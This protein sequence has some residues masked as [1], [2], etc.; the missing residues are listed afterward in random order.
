MASRVHLAHGSSLSVVHQWYTTDMT[1]IPDSTSS[2][3]IGDAETSLNSRRLLL[4]YVLGL[5]VLSA[6]TH[7]ILALDG[8]E[9]GLLAGILTA[10]M[11]LYYAAYLFRTRRSL[12]QI[13]FAPLV[14]HAVTYVVVV[15]GFQLHAAFLA[16]ANSDQL[17]GSNDFPLDPGWFG[18]TLAMAG[19][20]GIGLLAHAISSI[21]L[22]GFEN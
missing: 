2:A 7:V 19:F 6:I 3:A 5:V 10:V 17:R 22:R 9:I 12:R 18:P 20:W 14:A 21:S 1:T 13:R 16:F 8:G 11:A 15:G 4:P